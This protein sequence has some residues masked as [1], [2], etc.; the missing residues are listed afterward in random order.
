[1]QLI[2]APMA[3]FMPTAPEQNNRLG[4]CSRMTPEGR[5][6][7]YDVGSTTLVTTP[8][9]LAD[10]AVADESQLLVGRQVAVE[11]EAGGNR[12]YVLGIAVY[13]AAAEPSDACDRRRE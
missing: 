8:A 6:V 2:E 5:E 3:S 4:E 13:I 9:V 11:E 12:T 7:A 10:L 1:G